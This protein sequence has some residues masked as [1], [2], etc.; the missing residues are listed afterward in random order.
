MSGERS[1]RALKLVTATAADFHFLKREEEEEATRIRGRGRPTIGNLEFS[2]AETT[3]MLPLLL[4]NYFLRGSLSLGSG[5]IWT[6][7]YPAP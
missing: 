2:R 4:S 7:N 3:P 5:R 1:K 6:R